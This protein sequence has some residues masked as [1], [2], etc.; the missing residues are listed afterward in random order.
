MF[1]IEKPEFSLVTGDILTYRCEGHDLIYDNLRMI[2]DDGLS[3]YERNQFDSEW[4]I[5]GTNQRKSVDI[6]WNI[7]VTEHIQS[8]AIEVK[9]PPLRIIGKRGYLQCIGLS[10][11]EDY[12][13]NIN[14]T[15]IIEVDGK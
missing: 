15:Y 3:T 4:R 10:K 8:T 14:D 6:E 1:H 11:R 9:T 12:F 7:P 5:K 13:P 2:Y